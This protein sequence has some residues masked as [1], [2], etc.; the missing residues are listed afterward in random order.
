MPAQGTQVTN[1]GPELV[2]IE[3]AVGISNRVCRLASKAIIFW[4]ASSTQAGINLHEMLSGAYGND[5]GV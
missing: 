1:D 2:Q 4:S 3:Q 5:A